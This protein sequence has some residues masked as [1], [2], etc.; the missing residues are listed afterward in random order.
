MRETRFRSAVKQKERQKWKRG[1]GMKFLLAAINAKY[2][3][4]NLA[5]HSLKAYAKKYRNNIEIR[6]YTINQYLDDILKDIYRK[7][8]DALGFSCYIWNIEYV[9]ELTE[10]IHKVMPDTDIW[11]GGP[12]VSYNAEEILRSRPQIFGIMIGEGERTFLK[13]MEYYIGGRKTLK[14]IPGLAYRE[15][16]GTERRIIVRNPLKLMDINEIPFVYE[17]MEEFKNKIVYYESSRGCPFSC[18]YCLSS[19]DKKVRFRELELVKKEL[20]FFLDQK[21][22]Q[23]KFIDRTFNCKKSHAMEIWKFIKENDNGI[24]NFHFEISADLIDGE[25]LE[26]LKDVRPGLMQMEIG[27]QSVNPAAIHEIHR[28]MDLDKLK[29]VVRQINSNHN[30]HQHLD[31]IAGLPYEGYESFKKSFNWVYEREPEQLQLG[32]LKV[33]KGSYMYERAEQYGIVYKSKPPYEVLYTKWINY[34][35]ILA[36]KAVEEMV[37]IY[38]NS[39]QFKNSMKCLLRVYGEPFLMYK[40]LAG[41]YEQKGLTGVSHSRMQR[42]DILLDFATE[43]GEVDTEAFQEVLLYDLYLRENLKSRPVW[44]K[45]RKAY[46]ENIRRFYQN[47]RLREKYLNGYEKYTESQISRMTHIEAFSVNVGKYIQE[48]KKEYDR[49]YILFDY[50]IR[51]PLTYEACAYVIE[52]NR[53]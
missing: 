12:E 20:K 21:V 41:F 6:E 26:L 39:G 31:L 46:K 2:I 3:H 38:Y 19:I 45:D 29:D 7:K 42:Y 10:E 51:D 35:E 32:F 44:A 16:N 13:L 22:A 30:I 25:E 49:Q 50:Q 18:S 14:E 43:N 9:L 37:E 34:E 28:E 53:I 1:T 23:V 24:T 15:N 48:G 52:E 47:A 40:E 36:L 11:L 4:S 8:P 17:N 33:L 5:V 27:V